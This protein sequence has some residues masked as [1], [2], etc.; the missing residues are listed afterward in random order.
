[1][2][3]NYILNI[4]VSDTSLQYNAWDKA[5]NDVTLTCIN[6]GYTEIK[7]HYKIGSVINKLRNSINLIC[8][9]I[10]LNLKKTGNILIQYPGYKCN[11]NK[12]VKIIR[13]LT[14]HKISILIHDLDSY[15]SN[16][17]LN[18]SEKEILECA[19]TIYAH[20]PAMKRLI[21]N[22][23]NNNCEIK[24]LNLFDYYG[25]ID[26]IDKDA[27]IKN[28]IKSHSSVVFAGNLSKSLFLKKIKNWINNYPII[29][30]GNKIELQNPNLIYYGRFSPDDI[31]NIAGDWGLV[32]DG[33][34]IETCDGQ[35]GKYLKINAS[36]KAS[37]YLACGKPIIVWQQSGIAPYIINNK[38]GIAIKSIEE[39][40]TIIQ[41]ISPA[42]LSVL[43]NNAINES[44]LIRKGFHLK[45]IL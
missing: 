13:R 9:I 27:A 24:I 33:D 36:H 39:I 26:E 8:H 17:I 35:L 7:I 2:G 18:T 43:K 29:L 42:E 37:L 3:K 11:I 45:N 32:W 1:M 5:R 14:R 4:G 28:F 25:K 20:T 38:L 15:R 23:T 6:N 12:S 40:P 19:D 21:E 41:N 10:N 16:G 34:S 30:Y 31:N 22:H 44:L